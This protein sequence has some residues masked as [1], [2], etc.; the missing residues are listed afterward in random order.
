MIVALQNFEHR[1]A[2]SNFKLDEIVKHHERLC[3]QCLQTVNL[4]WQ[5]W[6]LILKG[7][8]AFVLLVFVYLHIA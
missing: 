2:N 4:R 3:R 7:R 6:Q 8:T 1:L 5:K